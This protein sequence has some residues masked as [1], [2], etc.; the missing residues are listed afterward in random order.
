M[1]S[2]RDDHNA[3]V[4]RINT[5]EAKLRECEAA[6]VAREAEIAERDA[7]I[8]R[9]KEPSPSEKPPLPFSSATAP[10]AAATLFGLGLGVLFIA[11]AVGYF[12]VA[13][14]SHCGF[15]R[16]QRHS[17]PVA[18]MVIQAPAAVHRSQAPEVHIQFMDPPAQAAEEAKDEADAFF[19]DVEARADLE[20]KVFEGNATAK[21]IR[22]LKRICTRIGDVDCRERAEE[23]LKEGKGKAKWRK[24]RPEV[25]SDADDR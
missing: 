3:A 4:L 25:P 24:A 5:L 23:M 12:R 19:E 7:E 9:L 22:L 6:L 16:H 21:E 14:R 15:G 11:G 13:G 1:S 2:Y 8:A 18:P 10:R 17:R 20:A